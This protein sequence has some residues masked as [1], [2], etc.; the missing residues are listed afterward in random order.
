MKIML[1]E[2]AILPTRAHKYDAGLDIYA[3]WTMKPT[4]IRRRGSLI[5][6][7]GVH[8]EIK[9]GYVGFLKSKSGLNVVHDITNEGVIDTGYTGSI[10][11]KLYNNGRKRYTIRPGDKISQLVILLIA[12]EDPELTTDELEQ[13]ERGDNGF[14]STGR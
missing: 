11:V 10:R 9:Q 2:G 13:T 8:V 7:T 4:T 12:L 6:D 14:G 3:P 1:D 5:I